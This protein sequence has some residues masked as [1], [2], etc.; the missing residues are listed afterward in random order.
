MNVYLVTI[1]TY[2][3]IG[4]ESKIVKLSHTIFKYVAGWLDDI[5]ATWK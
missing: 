2:N 5:G 4:D 3:K 1:S